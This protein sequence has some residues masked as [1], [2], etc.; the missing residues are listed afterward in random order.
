MPGVD[1]TYYKLSILSHLSLTNMSVPSLFS[2]ILKFASSPRV[3]LCAFSRHVSLVCRQSPDSKMISVDDDIS[4]GIL[5][6]LL[7]FVYAGEVTV[8]E[9]DVER[10]LKAAK[11]L[12]I[13]GLV[14]EESLKEEVQ[15]DEEEWNSQ[16][17]ICLIN[18][19]FLDSILN[20]L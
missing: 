7:E 4:P 16:S 10:L 1:H 14:S 9:A 6:A 5:R 13:I 19:R 20:I 3:V 8:D 2:A 18:H 11:R 15:D 12:K 17:L